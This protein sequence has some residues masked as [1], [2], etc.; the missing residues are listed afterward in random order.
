M[1]LD[2]LWLKEIHK[3]YTNFKNNPNIVK[4]YEIQQAKK[5]AKDVIQNCKK[6]WINYRVILL[7]EVWWDAKKVDEILKFYGVE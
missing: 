3:F 5:V 2:S 7:K 1:K 4:D 6:Y